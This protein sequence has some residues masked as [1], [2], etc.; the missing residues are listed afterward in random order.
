MR[1]LSVVRERRMM[2]QGFMMR[3]GAVT[4][5]HPMGENET[6]KEKIMNRLLTTTAVAL[7]MSLTPALA[8]DDAA[9][10]SDSTAVEKAKTPESGQAD[11]SGGAKG[12][13]SA[14]P[15]SDAAETMGGADASDEATTPD[16]GKADTSGAAMERSSTPPGSEAATGD[17]VPTDAG[18]IEGDAA[19]M[20]ENMKDGSMAGDTGS[21]DSI[22]EPK[23]AVKPGG[24]GE[25]DTSTGADIQSSAPPGSE[26]GEEMS[27][28][29]SESED[30]T[31]PAGGQADT[32]TGAKEQSSAPPSSDAAE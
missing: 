15:G 4:G 21:S 16:S 23:D 1:F 3:T 17:P 20:K 10:S 8:A 12:Q 29:M 6:R 26:A 5:A 14:P 27:D 11:T 31:K 24:S 32:S 28:D 18:D 7:V 25:A 2:K 30:A 19:D 9:T 22:S 13:S